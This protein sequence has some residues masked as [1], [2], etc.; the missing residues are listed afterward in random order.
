MHLVFF[1]L[2]SKGKVAKVSADDRF[3]R[4]SSNNESG[5]VNSSPKSIPPTRS[6]SGLPDGLFS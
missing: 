2:L 3:N 6:R 1:P 5:S 4:M